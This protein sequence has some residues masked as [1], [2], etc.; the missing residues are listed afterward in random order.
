MPR[1]LRPNHLWRRYGRGAGCQGRSCGSAPCGAEE[2]GRDRHYLTQHPGQEAW[3]AGAANDLD[4]GD[5]QADWHLQ[6]HNDLWELGKV[7]VN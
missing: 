5:P 7:N 2:G 3:Q 6:V 4:L 1:T